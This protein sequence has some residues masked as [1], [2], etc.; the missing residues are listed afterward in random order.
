MLFGVRVWK[1]TRDASMIAIKG[2][3]TIM[4]TERMSTASIQPPL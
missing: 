2:M 3:V 1:Y 4:S